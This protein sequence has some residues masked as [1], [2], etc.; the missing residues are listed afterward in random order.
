M[1]EKQIT[2]AESI[3]I[4]IQKSW[5]ILDALMQVYMPR[6]LALSLVT[7]H[8]NLVTESKCSVNMLA[9]TGLNDHVLVISTIFYLVNLI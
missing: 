1:I 8:F 7:N 3:E 5:I 4:S 2:R 6:K 9:I